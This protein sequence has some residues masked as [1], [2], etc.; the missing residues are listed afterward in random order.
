MVG[1]PNR[2]SFF[3]ASGMSL[4]AGSEQGPS[5]A[6]RTGSQRPFYFAHS[7]IRFTTDSENN[8]RSSKWRRSSGR[9]KERTWPVPRGPGGGRDGS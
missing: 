1:A 2:V 7:L 6:H 3:R 4:R 5:L 9:D 8:E